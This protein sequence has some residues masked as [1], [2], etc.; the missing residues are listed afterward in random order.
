MVNNGRG[1]P[2]FLLARM[3]VETRTFCGSM[4]LNRINH[5]DGNAFCNVPGA[6]SR[7][8]TK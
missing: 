5:M 3:V 7:G 6:D 4:C 2:V 8:K 1:N